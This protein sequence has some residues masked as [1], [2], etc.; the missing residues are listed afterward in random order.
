[1]YRKI[2]AEI[3]PTATSAEITYANA[4]DYE[5]CFLLRERRSATL[6]HMKDATLEVESNIFAA[7]KLKGKR[8]RR[9]QK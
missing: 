6:A 7:E 1:M 8:G 2:P 4:F 3:K 5:F 9:K